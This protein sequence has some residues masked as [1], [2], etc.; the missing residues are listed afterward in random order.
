MKFTPSSSL[1]RFFIAL[2]LAC[3]VVVG[4][5]FGDAYL[6]QRIQKEA[7][8][9]TVA[10]VSIRGL[11]AKRN[12]LINERD[13]LREHAGDVAVL[14]NA[15]VDAKNPLPFIETIEKTAKAH[16][17]SLKLSLPEKRGDILI[18]RIES[19]SSAAGL[20]SFL[21]AIEQLPYQAIVKEFSF[22]SLGAAG[23]GGES[24]ASRLVATVEVLAQ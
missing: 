14:E 16:G 18:I 21:H 12:S 20:L 19:E 2:G 1:Q 15:F 3:A 7:A 23:S 6:L 24:K 5:S 22:E 10:K 4:V 9:L 13:W 11:E 8:R 17:V